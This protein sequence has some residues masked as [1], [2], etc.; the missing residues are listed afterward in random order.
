MPS[1]LHDHAMEHSAILV[2]RRSLFVALN[3]FLI[4]VPCPWALLCF[5]RQQAHFRAPAALPP[6][7]GPRPPRRGG[8]ES[9]SDSPEKVE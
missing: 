8:I 2:I 5:V 3:S 9:R 7:L 4:A 1:Q 6:A